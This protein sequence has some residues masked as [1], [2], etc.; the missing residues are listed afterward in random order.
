[1]VPDSENSEKTL[2]RFLPPL[3]ISDILD[4]FADNTS[5]YNATDTFNAYISSRDQN[6]WKTFF[7]LILDAAVTNDDV[8]EKAKTKPLYKL[9]PNLQVCISDIFL[10]ILD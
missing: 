5:I 9:R 3:S 8:I 6:W 4:G 10:Q 2:E 7:G 1:M